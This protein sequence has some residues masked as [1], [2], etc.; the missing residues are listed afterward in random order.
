MCLAIVGVARWFVAT[1]H[2]KLRRA[3]KRLRAQRTE[4]RKA[5]AIVAAAEKKA[6]QLHDR[7]DKAKPRHILE[8]DE[9]LADARALAKIA[10]DQVLIAENLLRRIIVEEYPPAKQAHLRAKYGVHE[11]PDKR[12]FTF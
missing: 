6:S 5:E 7:A 3:R 11:V 9:A 4:F 2:R 12:P 10:H 1:A 8:A